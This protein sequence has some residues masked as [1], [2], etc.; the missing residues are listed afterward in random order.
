[1]RKF[2][3]TSPSICKNFRVLRGLILKLRDF[4]LARLRRTKLVQSTRV[5]TA[6]GGG[7]RSTKRVGGTI[8]VIE[9]APPPREGRGPHFITQALLKVLNFLQSSYNSADYRV[10]TRRV[11]WK[12]VVGTS[13]TVVNNRA[14][15]RLCVVH[16]L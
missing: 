7:E 5:Y 9:G 15:N 4:P 3:L 13:L 8:W 11:E 12:V 10:N 1:M 16:R 14:L 2:S 6:R